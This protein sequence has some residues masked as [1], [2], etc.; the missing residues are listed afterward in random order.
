M[1][2]PDW[3]LGIFSLND[4]E[5]RREIL[6]FLLKTEISI[7]VSKPISIL[8][9]LKDVK[10]TDSSS[11][12][13][14]T[15]FP[16]QCVDVS[17][18]SLEQPSREETL[19]SLEVGTSEMLS[20]SVPERARLTVCLLCMSVFLRGGVAAASESSSSPAGSFWLPASRISALLCFKRSTRFSLLLSKLLM[21]NLE[22]GMGKIQVSFMSLFSSPR[23]IC[24]L[25]NKH[26]SSAC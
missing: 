25:Q 15:C 8:W 16:R 20:A 13:Q 11:V 21:A 17:S 12:Q 14:P 23:H 2:H 3:I 19:G 9:N 18:S 24:T 7:P 22:K 26:L 4:G 6:I 5:R 1:N 10:D